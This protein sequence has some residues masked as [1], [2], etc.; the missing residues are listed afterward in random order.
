MKEDDFM[1]SLLSSVTATAAEPARKR[2]SSP[3]MPSSDAAAPSSDSSFFGGVKKRYGQESDDE[4]YPRRR[5]GVGKKPRVSDMTIVPDEIQPDYGGMD[6]DLS[7]QVDEPMVKEEVVSD[8]DEEMEIKPKAAPLLSAAT[9]LNGQAGVRR[10]VVNSTSVK[11]VIP[12][13]EPISVKAEPDTPVKPRTGAELKPTPN[14]AAHW[15]AVQD[16]LV[17]QVKTS[18]LDAVK[19]PVGSI[20]VENVIEKDG[21]LRIFWLDQMEMDGVVHLVGKVL[22]RQSNKYVSACLSINGIKRNLFV[23]PRVKRYRKLRVSILRP[24]LPQ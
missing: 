22:D 18:E 14:G 12:K 11:H 9:K 24:Y 20:K 1:A 16:S 6:P 4:D 21:S 19:A 2:R 23:K 13:P 3:E 17:G 7:L 10:K 15:S 8:G 5:N